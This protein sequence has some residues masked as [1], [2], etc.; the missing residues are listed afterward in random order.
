MENFNGKLAIAL[1]LWF[2]LSLLLSG[3]VVDSRLQWDQISG[4]RAVVIFII[5]MTTTTLVWWGYR[6]LR[7]D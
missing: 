4:G 1:I 5:G 3:I 7:G 2:A 6:K